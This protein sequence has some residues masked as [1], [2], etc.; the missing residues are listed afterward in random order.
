MTGWTA[1]TPTL[2]AFDD[3]TLIDLTLAG[4]AE[5]FAILMDRH[6]VALKRC[7]GSMVQNADAEDLL[8]DALLKIWRG[9]S[10]FRSESSFRTWMTRVAI[11]EV[12]QSYR[13]DC[14]TPLRQPA[15]D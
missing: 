11:N 15:G 9:L 14:R 13:R 3:S 8:Q 7:I 1:M 12:L 4:R 5:C 10:T 2:A 6:L